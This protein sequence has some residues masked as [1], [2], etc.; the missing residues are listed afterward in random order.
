MADLILS[1]ATEDYVNPHAADGIIRASKMIREAGF[2][3]CHNVVARLVEALVKWGRQDCIDEIKQC[4]IATHSLTHSHH[5]TINE[6][7][8]IDDFDLA[9]R[10]FR[11]EE[12]EAVEIIQRI[13]GTE[14]LVAANPPGASVSYVAQ[15]G[16]ADMGFKVY[17]AAYTIDCVKG[18][19]VSFCNLLNLHCPYDLDNFINFTKEDVLELI[20]KIAEKDICMITH[21]PAKN[22]IVSYWDRQNYYKENNDGEWI[23]SDMLPEEKIKNFEEN[24]RFFLEKIKEDERINV[25]GFADI[26]KRYVHPRSV[27]REQIPEIKKA[28]S[29]DF[30]PLTVPE[31][32]CLSDILLACRDFLLG[33]EE[34]ECEKVYGFL[35]VPYTIPHP[36]RVTAA[37]MRESATQIPDGRFLPTEIIVGGK[38]LGPADWLRAALIIL[39]GEEV[40]NVVPDKWQ[41]DLNEFP[42][43]RNQRLVG[44]WIHSDSFKDE[45]ISNRARLQSWT[46][47]LP[48]GTNRKIF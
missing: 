27:K 20:E 18:R 36:V 26:I 9:M 35:E 42:M 43:L 39:S 10:L 1:F 15:Y 24:L 23:L 31:S 17:P 40:A 14:S 8:D 11:K 48:R 22:T 5:P 44:W 30:F 16:Y 47:R 7:T 34:H 6:Y 19:P 33:K 41:I 13:L 25:I 29:E 45:Y 46:I 38:K 4:E 12:D 2:T 32:L 3:L 37:E 28:L 21:H